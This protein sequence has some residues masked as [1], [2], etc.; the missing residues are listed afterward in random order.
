M[1]NDVLILLYYIISGCN[2]L[3]EAGSATNNPLDIPKK[4]RYYILATNSGCSL[5][6]EVGWSTTFTTGKLKKK[7][8][9]PTDFEEWPI[10]ICVGFF[11]FIFFC[12]CLSRFRIRSA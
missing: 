5:L 8:S 9:H 7:N 3:K 12:F 10:E 11:F 4:F 6:E 2:L 1:V